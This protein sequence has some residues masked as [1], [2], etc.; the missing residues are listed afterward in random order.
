MFSIP[1]MT[2][3]QKKPIDVNIGPEIIG[4]LN[5]KSRYDYFSSNLCLRIRKP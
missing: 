3:S 5:G 4:P 2:M 1:V